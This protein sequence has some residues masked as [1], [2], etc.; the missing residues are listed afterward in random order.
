MIE[1]VGML[2][3]NESVIYVEKHDDKLIAGTATNCG[4]IPQYETEYDDTFSM[5]ENLQELIEV[6]EIDTE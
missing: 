5:D 4:M 3:I 2:E 6:I 1:Y